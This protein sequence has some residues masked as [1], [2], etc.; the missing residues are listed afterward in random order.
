MMLLAS[1]TDGTA[2]AG[3]PKHTDLPA[4]GGK[5]C[6]GQVM[7]YLAQG[8]DAV[9]G[10]GIGNVAVQAGLTVQEVKAIVEAYCAQ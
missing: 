10:P 8:N 3:S 9:P 2:V 6:V 4:P 1:V 5:N 7:A